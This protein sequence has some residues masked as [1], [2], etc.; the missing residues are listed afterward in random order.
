MKKR[1]SIPNELTQFCIIVNS[2]KLELPTLS[3]KRID[4]ILGADTYYLSNI[5][6]REHFVEAVER[7]KTYALEYTCKLRRF[8]NLLSRATFSVILE[9]ER[10]EEQADIYFTRR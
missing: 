4:E 1:I 6:H 9:L 5:T 8:D 2:E 10:R 7:L 3:A